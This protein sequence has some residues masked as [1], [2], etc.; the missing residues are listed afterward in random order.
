[1]VDLI[2]SPSVPVAIAV[3]EVVNHLKGKKRDLLVSTGGPVRLLY[4]ECEDGDYRIRV[5][6]ILEVDMPSDA[7]PQNEILDGTGALGMQTGQIRVMRAPDNLTVLG[8]SNKSVLT[9]YYI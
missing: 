6:D 8:L 9:F 1:M 2:G 5:G 4:L 7:V 3:S